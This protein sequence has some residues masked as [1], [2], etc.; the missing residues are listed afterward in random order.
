MEAHGFLSGKC[1]HG[2]SNLCTLC[3]IEGHPERYTE[4]LLLE[5]IQEIIEA[6]RVPVSFDLGTKL[7]I[8]QSAVNPSVSVEK[9]ADDAYERAKEYYQVK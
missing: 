1:K 4:K 7:M 6:A 9:Q 8:W 3:D 2:S 5:V